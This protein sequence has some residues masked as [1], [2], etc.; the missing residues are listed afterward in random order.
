MVWPSAV[1]MGP[2]RTIRVGAQWTPTLV[3]GCLSLVNQVI[4][5]A[6][7]AWKG[8]TCAYAVALLGYNLVNINLWSRIAQNI[9][10]HNA[11]EI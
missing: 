1:Q 5:L 7:E 4:L 8:C 9:F 11:F 6:A 10:L 3:Y 2:I